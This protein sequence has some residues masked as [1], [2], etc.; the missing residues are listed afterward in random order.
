MRV[1]SLWSGT[2]NW[3]SSRFFCSPQIL[4]WTSSACILF[5]MVKLSKEH[6]FCYKWVSAEQHRTY[7]FCPIWK[8]R[9]W[10]LF[11]THKLFHTEEGVILSSGFSVLILWGFEH[12]QLLGKS[13]GI[14][15]F[16]TAQEVLSPW[17]FQ[18]PDVESIRNPLLIWICINQIADFKISKEM[19]VYL[20][21]LW[22]LN[23]IWR[24]L[25]PL[26]LLF[27][28]MSFF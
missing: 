20:N 4:L 21:F 1:N 23:C 18:A 25:S 22:L 26:L 11:S 6:G 2:P 10:N 15:A 17:K 13:I 28:K 5:Q 24:H 3:C 12:L 7:E 16:S 14:R 8:S 19:S 27:L 9:N